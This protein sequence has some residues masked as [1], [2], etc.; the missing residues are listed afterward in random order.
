MEG[1]GADT[2]P[3]LLARDGTW[4]C[5][6]GRRLGG[7]VAIGEWGPGPRAPLNLNPPQSDLSIE[8][9]K[10]SPSLE[11]IEHCK[12][13]SNWQYARKDSVSCLL[14]SLFDH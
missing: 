5:R 6:A 4:G 3:T 8:R 1:G 11:Y 2:A 13:E 12:S 10:K 14:L 9:L 7:G